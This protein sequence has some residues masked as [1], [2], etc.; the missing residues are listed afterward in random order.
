MIDRTGD[1]W[2]ADLGDHKT[3][4]KGKARRLLIGPRARE[5]LTPWLLPDEPDEPIFSPRRVDDRQTR[6]QGKRLPGRFYCRSS[7]DQVLRR[8]VKRAGVDPW[9]LGQ[10]R[11]SAAVRITDT[12]DLEAARQT[13]G[14]SSAA[15]TRHYAAGADAHALDAVRRTG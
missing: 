10:C 8:A 4:H 2:T 6:R 3:A 1:V 15:M 9:T 12:A 5:A 13:L 11:H 14:H 7:L